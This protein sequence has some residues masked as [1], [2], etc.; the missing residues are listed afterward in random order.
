[1]PVS[2]VGGATSPGF[3][4]GDDPLAGIR[5]KGREFVRGPSQQAAKELGAELAKKKHHHADAPLKAAMES[6]AAAL[7]P[8]AQGN[9]SYTEKNEAVAQTENLLKLL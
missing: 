6:T 3:G 5:N 7:A 8:V 1:M 9:A 4:A 2:G